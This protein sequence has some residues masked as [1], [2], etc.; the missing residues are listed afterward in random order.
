MYYYQA[1][2]DQRL[3]TTR[4]ILTEAVVRRIRSSIALGLAIISVAFTVCTLIL[5]GVQTTQTIVEQGPTTPYGQANYTFSGYVI[6]P[7]PAHSQ[8]VVA[9]DAYIPYSLTFSLFPAASGNLSPTGPALLVLSNFTGAPFR[10]SATAPAAEPY[11]IFIASTNRTAY[12]IAIKG[13]WSLFY[14]LRGYV[15]VGFLAS[16]ASILAASYFRAFERRKVVEE[17]AVREARSHGA[18]GVA[19]LR[20]TQS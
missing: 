19:R 13:T 2:Q 16:L 15:F 10:V 11:A 6:P 3:F 17:E 7:V 8:I 18:E 1:R 4:T 5:P 20:W 14:V 12:A 9:I